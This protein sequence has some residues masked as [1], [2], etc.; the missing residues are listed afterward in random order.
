MAIWQ[1]L[2]WVTWV[3]AGCG[4]LYGLH[5]LCLRLEERGLLY[6]R[7]RQPSA[8]SGGC[9]TALQQALEP[10]AQHVIQLEDEKREK[11]KEAIPGEGD[12]IAARPIPDD[13]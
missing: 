13:D 1:I 4:A 8:S 2:F 6:Y 7:N 10:Q 3:I 5:R 9:F 12:D 11:L